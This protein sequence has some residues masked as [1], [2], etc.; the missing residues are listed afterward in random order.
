MNNF[1]RVNQELFCENV[2][3]KDIATSVGTPVYVYSKSSIYN[4]I[5]ILLG[6]FDSRKINICFSIKSNSNLSIIRLMAEKNLGADI[7]SGGELYKALKANISPQKIV[8]SGVGKTK[9]ELKYALESNIGLINVESEQELI[10]LSEIAKSLNKIANISFRINPDIDAKT[11]VYT[12]TAKKENK[13]GIPINNAIEIYK[14]AHSIPY[15]NTKGI[16]CHLGSPILSLEPYQNAL[17]KIKDLYLK[18]KQ[19]GIDIN[20]I[21]LGGGFG[22]IYKDEKPFTPIQFAKL[23]SNY[24]EFSNCSII[25]EPGR[26]IVGNAGVLITKVLYIK[27]SDTKTFIICDAGMNDLIRPALYNSYHSI[28]PVVLG[29]NNKKII[30]DIV[31]PICESG[32]FFAKDREIYEIEQGSLLAIKS[33]GAYG[34]SMSSNYNSR[35]RS[36]EV[37]VD[38]NSFK[39]IRKRETYQDLTILEE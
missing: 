9:D 11:H 1:N 22:I 4:N 13:F 36:C 37:L 16:A 2:A 26:F 10:S 6:A 32:D 12:S 30:A 27:H 18:L 5:E 34:F 33:A 24:S 3:L 15:I 38:N 39:L 31:G 19:E 29:N 20:T 23:L 8:F 14:K 35:P 25:I 7:V 28:E 21:D 17:D